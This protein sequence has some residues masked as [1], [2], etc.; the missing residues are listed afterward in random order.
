MNVHQSDSSISSIT[1]QLAF[2]L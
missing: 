1:R 2:I